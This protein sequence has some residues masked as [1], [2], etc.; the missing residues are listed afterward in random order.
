[1][2]TKK[3]KAK[4]KPSQCM[5]VELV[6]KQLV[7]RNAAIDTEMCFNLTTGTASLQIP[8]PLKKLDAKKRGRLPTMVCTYCPICGKDLRSTKEPK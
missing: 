7:S 2:I 4:P 3:K 8:V 1:M 5:C 6:N